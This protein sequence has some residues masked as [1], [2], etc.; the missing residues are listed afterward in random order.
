MPHKRRSF[1]RGLRR[2]TDW[3]GSQPLSSMVTVAAGTAALL[4]TFTP[5]PDGETIIRLRGLFNWRSDQSTTDEFQIGAYGIAVVS[6]QAATVGIAAVPHPDTDASWDGWMYHTY[7]CSRFEFLSGV[8]VL[9]DMVHTIVIDNKAMRKITGDDRLVLVVENSS[10][11][12]IQV[13]DQVRIL[14][15]V[16]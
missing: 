13:L 9:A 16:N 14:S 3:V 1:S 7:F 2:A 6:E 5:F 10:G 8:G 11:T 15:K 12:G 4:Q